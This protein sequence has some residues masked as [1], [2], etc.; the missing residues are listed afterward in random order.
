[1]SLYMLQKC[2]LLIRHSFLMRI[3]T[4]IEPHVSDYVNGDLRQD[5][6]VNCQDEG[7]YV[8]CYMHAAART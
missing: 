3:G 1:M 5:N 6:G 4:M 8:T 2:L 7:I